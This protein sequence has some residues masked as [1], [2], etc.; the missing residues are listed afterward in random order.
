M[1]IIFNFFWKY[2]FTIL[3]FIY[4]ALIYFYINSQPVYIG[5]TTKFLVSLS[6]I[7]LI[8]NILSKIKW[9]ILPTVI[10]CAIISFDAY[11]SFVLKS[12]VTLGVIASIFETNSSEAVEYVK[13]MILPA[14]GIFAFTLTL[15]FLALREIK[16][17]KFP[18]KWSYVLMFLFLFGYIPS[19]VYIDIQYS[20][21]IGRVEIKENPVLRIQHTISRPMPIL[22]NDLFTVTSY[23]IERNKFK[24]YTG[25]N[26]VLP[27]GVTLSKNDT[28]VQKIYY[29]IGE[30]A[31]RKHLSLYG[32]P[33][34][35]TP[36]LDSLYQS[37]NVD[38][39]YF[40]AISPAPM[41]RDGLRLS[42]TFATPTNGNPF[43]SEKNMVDLANDAGYETVWISNQE[44]I[45]QHDSYFGFIASC[46]SL[47]CY[48][49]T[50]ENPYTRDDLDLVEILQNNYREGQKQ[51][52]FIHL[53]GSHIRYFERSD[54]IDKLA[55]PDEK[56]EYFEYDRSIHHTD[57]VL[58]GIYEIAKRDSSSVLMYMSDHGEIINT[59]HGL[60]G[61]GS[62][63]FEIPYLYINNSSYP[64]KTIIE[65]YIDQ[66]FGIINCS[67]L[68]YIIA[69]ILGYNVADDK[70]D[71]AISD[72]RYIF[73]SDQQPHLYEDVLKENK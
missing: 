68:I 19:I 39:N 44:K 51:F 43:Y 49:K 25:T 45:G 54:D 63:Q 48:S 38:F 46:A 55:I 29:I 18:L 7:L 66:S 11:F 4:L 52:F 58:R 62:A 9:N 30:S 64:V 10:L 21:D 27:E 65:K 14:L 12:Q 42:L 57:R 15:T 61:K 16:P 53:M 69:Q 56:G 50:F 28:T 70:I 8:Y 36:F 2:K 67:N 47:N 17:V 33:I 6:N 23:F 72:G 31:Y 32:Y 71:R 41:T 24:K 26:R 40:E 1:Y 60:M 34:K 20:G 3:C 37:N 5:Y 59:G 35:T 73:H 13:N 22:Y